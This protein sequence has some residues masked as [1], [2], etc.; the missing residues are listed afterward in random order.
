MG[1]FPALRAL[2]LPQAHS[3]VLFGDMCS[4]HVAKI[5]VVVLV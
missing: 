2:G 3:L 5:A 1:H 4:I